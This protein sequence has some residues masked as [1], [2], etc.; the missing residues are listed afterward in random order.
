MGELQTFGA[1]E[2]ADLH[3]IARHPGVVLQRNDRDPAAFENL[4][5]AGHRCVGGGQY[6]H[7][8]VADTVLLVQLANVLAR[9]GSPAGEGT[10]ELH[11]G[12]ARAGRFDVAVPADHI[13]VEVVELIVGHDGEGVA[14]NLLAVAVVAGEDGGAADYRDA[15]FGQGETAGIDGLLA[16]SHHEQAVRAVADQGVQELQADAGQVLHF[17]DDDRVE[18]GVGATGELVPRQVSCDPQRIVPIQNAPAGQSL[19]VILVQL[20]HDGASGGAEGSPA[21][22]PGQAGVLVEVG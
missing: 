13:D 5:P 19:G 12:S 18:A 9:C 16:I 11:H 21:T 8:A 17:V 10:A 15:G 4:S 2:G 22:D 6:G 3:L 1:M 20:P 14:K 7:V